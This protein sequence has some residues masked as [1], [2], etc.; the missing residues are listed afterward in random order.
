MPLDKRTAT[1]RLVNQLNAA[2]FALGDAERLN[3]EHGQL[4]IK[5]ER[6]ATIKRRTLRLRN[7][8]VRAIE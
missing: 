3:E 4:V 6:I 1:V 7:E 2:L 8:V 5:T